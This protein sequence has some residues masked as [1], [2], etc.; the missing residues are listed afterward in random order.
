MHIAIIGG[1]STIGVTIAYT[2][3]TV[4]PTIDLTLVDKNQKAAWAHGLD[5]AH[6]TFHSTQAPVD[7]ETADSFGTIQA[8]ASNELDTLDPDLIVF[9]AAAPQPDDAT[10]TDARDAELE[11]N[12]SIVDSVAPA[13]RSSRPVPV[14]VLSNPIDRITYRLWKQVGW[15]R[16]YFLG[17]SVSETARVAHRIGELQNVHPRTVYC[18]VMGEHGNEI[19]PVFSRL[20][21]DGST[22]TLPDEQRSEVRR[23]AQEIPFEIAKERGVS[24]TSRWVT[25]AGVVRII[26]KMMVNESSPTCLSTP[27]SGEY[28]FSDGCLSVPVTVT[29][30]GVTDIVEWEL[31]AEEKQRLRSAHET[32]RTDLEI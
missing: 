14:L 26:R 30:D 8:V 13:L 2:L 28:G 9:T 31:S 1:A 17:Y 18:P 4:D 25:S 5:I 24:E 6:S 19:V 7:R 3:A 22:T 21:I 15:S 16:T 11:A 12:R 29:L 27:L 20:R 32:I 10:T 23:Y